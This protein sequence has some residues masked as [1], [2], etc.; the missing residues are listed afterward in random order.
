MKQVKSWFIKESPQRDWGGGKRGIYKERW[1]R[2][3]VSD[4]LCERASNQAEKELRK[5]N[6]VKKIKIKKRNHSHQMNMG[7]RR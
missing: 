3:E 6:K 7:S 5:V 4:I 2:M 1:L